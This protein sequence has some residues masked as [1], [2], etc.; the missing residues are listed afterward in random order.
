MI[1][2]KSDKDPIFCRIIYIISLKFEKQ[3]KCLTQSYTNLKKK[4]TIKIN[5]MKL[6]LSSRRLY[7]LN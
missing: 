7:F 5:Y 3:T 2:T 4:E 1:Q 6:V